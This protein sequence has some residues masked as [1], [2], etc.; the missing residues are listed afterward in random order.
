M[1]HPGWSLKLANAPVSWGVDYPDDPNNPPWSRVL[2][3]IALAG[4][5][6]IELGPYGY[7]PT[8]PD[9]LRREYSSRGL[10]AVA[11]FVFQPL[12]DLAKRA[13]IL[14]IAR[15]TCGLLAALGAGTLVTIDHISDPRMATAGRADLRPAPPADL[16][17]HL[18]E[19]VAAVAD[20]ALATGVR[21]A[22]HQ[23]A[24]CY[25]EFED[26]LEAALDALDAERVGLC[27]DTGHM[28]YAGIDPVAFYRRHH[29]RVRHLHFKDLDPLVHA[30]IL[31]DAVPFLDAVRKRIFCPLGHGVVRWTE[32]RQALAEHG[33]RGF[34]TVEQD[35]DAATVGAA[36]ADA[37]ASLAFLGSAGF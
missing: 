26:E 31:R 5:A 6:C 14:E 28:A 12:H 19:T 11:G 24:G 25:L 20:V 18:Y 9:R 10:Q 33:Y 8:D 16:Y 1:A 34:A 21:V 37:R 3:E 13:E 23:H 15:R 7:L 2:D 30:R 27:V 17:H 29:G 36:L 32:L 35:I 22:V 4:Y